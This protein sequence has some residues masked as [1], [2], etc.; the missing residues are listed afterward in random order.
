[1]NTFYYVTDS[2][3]MP[4]ST[5][6]EPSEE[7]YFFEST[8][9]NRPQTTIHLTDQEIR[10]FAKRIADYITRRTFAGTMESFDFQIDVYKRQDIRQTGRSKTPGSSRIDPGAVKIFG[11]FRGKPI[12]ALS[13]NV[14]K[15]VPTAPGLSS[16][17]EP[18]D[19]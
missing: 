18:G 11:C 5:R 7:Y 15:F 3:Q 19:F 13:F 6:K 8:R 17:D 16:D 9:F 1:M 2:A 4:P 12:F 14:C 10:T